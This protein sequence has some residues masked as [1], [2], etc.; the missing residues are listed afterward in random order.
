M[1]WLSLASG[2]APVR[3]VTGDPGPGG[4]SESAPGMFGAGA[5]WWVLGISVG[6]LLAG[7]LYLLWVR[8]RERRDPDG[9]AARGMAR[10]LRLG[11]GDLAMIDQI[12]RRTSLGTPLELL[13][14]VKRLE[15]AA[16]RFAELEGEPTVR[17]RLMHL[18]TRLDIAVPAAM[19]VEPG[20]S[21][22]VQAKPA[23]GVGR[24][25]PTVARAKLR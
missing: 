20:G 5:A 24:S 4:T 22:S 8:S 17:R 3:L 6:V 10:S 14:S 11:R 2:P 12:S 23:V 7:G 15:R 16:E 21:K 25:K 9:A 18:C 19:A 1:T 13:L